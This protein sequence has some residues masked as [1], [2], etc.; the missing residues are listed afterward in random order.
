MVVISTCI[1]AFKPAGTVK[2]NRREMETAIRKSLVL[3]QSSSHTFLVNAGGCHSCHGQALGAIAFS[4]AKENGYEIRDEIVREAVD[5]ICHT[6]QS[7][8]EN[9]AQNSDPTAVIMTGSYDLWALSATG[10]APT[11]SM[12]LLALNI[13]RR[14][15]KKGNWVSP[16][17]RP[18][19]VLFIYG[20]GAGHQKQP[21]FHT[22]LIE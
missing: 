18:P 10:F 15:N 9:L 12:Q 2:D 6:W 20:Y 22:C 7:R 19:G 14:Q 4:M 16:N 13:L 5:S 1:V 21:V 8:I 3:L 17:L 11:K